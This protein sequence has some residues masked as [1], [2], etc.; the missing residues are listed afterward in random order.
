MRSLIADANNDLIRRVAVDTGIISTVGGS[1]VTGFSGDDGQATDA[2]LNFPYYVALDAAN[3]LV[4]AY[5]NNGPIR[6][7]TATPGIIPTLPG[8]GVTGASGD[9]RPAARAQ[10]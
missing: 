2:E 7:G 5:T 1:G 10:P 8:T 6:K 3:N 4:I 9:H